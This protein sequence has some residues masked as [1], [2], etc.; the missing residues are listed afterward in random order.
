M[1]PHEKWLKERLDSGVMRT[2]IFNTVQNAMLVYYY[3][4]RNHFVN[5]NHHR[6]QLL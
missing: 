2:A 1:S 6:L 4:H 5:R 3:G